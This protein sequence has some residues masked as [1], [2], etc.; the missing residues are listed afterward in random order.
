MLKSNMPDGE[1]LSTSFTYIEGM[2]Q[3]IMLLCGPRHLVIV[4]LGWHTMDKGCVELS[5]SASVVW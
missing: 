5:T 1:S 4:M 3:F 2:K